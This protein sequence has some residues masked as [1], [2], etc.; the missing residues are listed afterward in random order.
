MPVSMAP[1]GGPSCFDRVKMGFMIGFCVGM[2][3]GALFGGFS[4]L[5][6][7]LKGHF[8]LDVKFASIIAVP[9]VKT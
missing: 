5:R 9:S 1:T 8:Y 3:S 2:G 6:Y 4:A 7:V